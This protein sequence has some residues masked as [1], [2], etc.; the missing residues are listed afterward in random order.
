MRAD[1]KGKT[2]YYRDERNNYEHRLIAERALG[3]PLKSDEEVHHIDKDGL[4]NANGNL[5]ILKRPLHMLLHA[6]ER[7]L[8][9]CGNP[10]WRPCVICK[11][12]DDPENMYFKDR[13]YRHRECHRLYEQARR[14]R[15]R[16]SH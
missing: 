2:A 7:A 14:K 3:R 13:A 1:P 9:A 5:V 10:D 11:V 8:A 15:K 4:K 6:R 12:Y 16:D